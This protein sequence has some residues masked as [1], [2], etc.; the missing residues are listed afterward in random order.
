MRR[1]RIKKDIPTGEWLLTYSDLVTLVLVFFVLLY[2]FSQIDVSKFRQF[3]LSFQGSGILDGGRAPLEQVMPE[4][5][6]SEAFED[7]AALGEGAQSNLKEIYNMT[8]SYLREH[9]LSDQVEVGYRQ[10][11]IALEIKE[12]ILFDSGKAVLKPEA[13][14]LL[15][16]LSGLFKKLPNQISVEGHTDNRPIQTAQYP[17]NWELSV[18]RAAKVVRYLTEER[19]L[20]PRKFVA[21][22]FG[23]YQPVLPNTSPENQAQNRRVV[24]VITTQN[25]N[26]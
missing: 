4:S 3:I 6:S 21:V 1:C 15:D 22:G 14:Q 13:R 23:E 25:I 19:G 18:D 8:V 11:G 10:R 12:R 7:E 9:G 26:E 24:L 17:T 16:R 2:S 5:T 20:D